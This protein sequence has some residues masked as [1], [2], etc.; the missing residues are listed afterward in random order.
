MKQLLKENHRLLFTLIHK[1]NTEKGSRY[2]KLSDRDD[3]IIMTDEA[4]RTQ[5]DALALNM[6][7]A[8]PNASFLAFTGTPLLAEGEEKTK[9]TFGDYVSIYNFRESI[10]DHATVPLYYENKTP[11]LQLINPDLNDDIYLAIEDAD[12]DERQE[13][14]LSRE[15]TREY[16]VLTRDDRLNAISENIV[17]HFV[18]RGYGGKAMVVSIDKFTTVKMFDKVQFFWKKYIEGL[19]TEAT[20]IENKEDKNDAKAENSTAKIHRHGSRGQPR[21]E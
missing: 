10:D 6:R 4:H 5:Y 15:F 2:P 19:E 3:I 7:E 11:E 13:E 9:D 16:Q 21:T 12:L 17:N 8:L 20:Q 1:F 14:K 18:N